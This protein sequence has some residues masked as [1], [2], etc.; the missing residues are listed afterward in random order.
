MGYKTALC[1]VSA[2]L[3]A[4]TTS[5]A[6]AVDPFTVIAAF[7]LFATPELGVAIAFAANVA[8]AAGISYAAQALL[9]KKPLGAGGFNTPET[10]YSTRQTIPSKREIYGT[11]LVGGALFFEKTVAPYL[12]QG[13]LIKDGLGTSIDD[14]Y[15]GNNKLF[16]PSG[17][18]AGA[19]L[20]PSSVDGQPDYAN[21]LRCSI[22]LGADDQTID[23][24][25]AARF[26]TED[27][28]F[29][30]RGVMTIVFEFKHPADFNAYQAL[31]GNSQSPSVLFVVNGTPYVF[32]PRDPT[33]DVTD[34]R[35]WKFSR[36]ASLIQ[37]SYLIN[38]RGGRINPNRIV[39]DR[40]I[41]S[42]NYD[43]S[44]MGTKEGDFLPIH[45]LDALVQMSQRPAEVMSGMLSANRGAVVQEGGRV[46]VDSSQPKEVVLVVTDDLIIGGL[47]YT[48][49]KNRRDLV[50]IVEPRFIASE[51]DYQEI[52]G[53]QY[54][55]ESLIIAYGEEH[56]SA[57]E[58]PC[59]LDNRRCQ[60][61]A[62]LF[63]LEAALERGLAIIVD[64]LAL[65]RAVGPLANGIMQID[66]ELFPQCNG[67][68]QIRNYS[69][70]ENFAGISITGTQYDSSI[71]TSWNAAV[72]QQDFVE[73]TS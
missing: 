52:A 11:A 59:T 36:N 64:L 10:R 32:D 19:I 72:D 41:D 4:A 37:T 16:F 6:W 43:D 34:N 54:R 44:L 68:Y 73:P 55:N 40:I 56:L 14:I 50:N 48:P 60:R 45:T 2:A 5:T 23:P 39:W 15:V 57:L 27:T 63:G 29:R 46:W 8:I 1:I 20:T 7:S 28:N 25:I 30:Q 18:T 24:L 26:P 67:L 42:A 38:T 33:Q 22:R 17:I 12:V 49:Y 71:E 62:K 9:G 21:N 69:F 13:F 35:T 3:W 61:L 70:A 47:Q 66:S 31:W 51:L 65:E 58:L 53:P